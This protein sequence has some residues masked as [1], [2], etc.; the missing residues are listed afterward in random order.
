[1][2]RTYKKEETV[3]L[4]YMYTCKSPNKKRRYDNNNN[5]SKNSRGPNLSSEE[6]KSLIEDK[7]AKMNDKVQG[8]PYVVVTARDCTRRE[9][10]ARNKGTKWLKDMFH[11]RVLVYLR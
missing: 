2:S 8:A 9:R 4:V 1:M 3:R 6:S 7:E 5:N 11:C 10:A